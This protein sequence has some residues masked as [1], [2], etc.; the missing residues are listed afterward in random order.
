MPNILAPL[1]G[2]HDARGNLLEKG[3][4]S[5][6]QFDQIAGDLTAWLQY[7][8]DPSILQRRSLGPWVIGFLVVF[9]LLAYLLKR[10]YWRDIH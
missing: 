6:Q 7:A 2:V 3:S 4:M 10:A 1:E 5:Q 9:S 8:S